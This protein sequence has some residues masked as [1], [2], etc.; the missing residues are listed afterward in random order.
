VFYLKPTAVKNA[1]TAKVPRRT[2]PPIFNNVFSRSVISGILGRALNR[3]LLF[4]DL[5]AF[6]FLGNGAP[7]TSTRPSQRSRYLMWITSYKAKM[8]S[9][10][11]F[12]ALSDKNRNK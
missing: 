8:N 12:D 1:G 6:K 11:V 2:P 4:R 3:G 7:V 5:R 9:G 10:S